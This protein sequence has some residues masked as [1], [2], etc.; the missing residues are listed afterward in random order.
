MPIAWSDIICRVMTVYHEWFKVNVSVLIV[1][2]NTHR[3]TVKL[4]AISDE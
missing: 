1:V 2:V 3:Q 4:Q